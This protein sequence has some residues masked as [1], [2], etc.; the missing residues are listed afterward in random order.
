MKDPEDDNPRQ[1][2][3]EDLPAPED[4]A[5]SEN[6]E[7]RLRGPL[8]SLFQEMIRRTLSLGL[9]GF[10]MTEEP[11]RRA[12]SESL[13]QEWIDY[14]G[15]QTGDV[16]NDLAER[17]AREFGAWLRGFDLAD[18][19]RAIFDQYEFSAKI[20]LSA[21]AKEEDPPA[22]LKVVRRRK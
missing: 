14:L 18:V 8:E 6:A 9:G 12:I 20:D 7:D 2:K 22:S 4:V 3:P 17:L 11:V 15:R 19:L 5:E 1:L 21:R 16:R 10:F 13:P